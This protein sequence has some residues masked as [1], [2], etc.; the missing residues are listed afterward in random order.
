MRYPAR[1][2][3]Q[4]ISAQAK[5]KVWSDNYLDEN[6]LIRLNGRLHNAPID[7]D[8]KFAYLLPNKYPLTDLL[9]RNTHAETFHYGMKATVTCLRQRYT[10]YHIYE[11][12][13]TL[14]LGVVWPAGRWQENH[15]YQMHEAPP[16]QT[17]DSKKHLPSQ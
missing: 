12:Q 5:A 14:N 11:Q 1:K 3:R 16:L 9:I 13:S 17:A 4:R 10:G 2:T 15:I 7:M 6:E 8:T